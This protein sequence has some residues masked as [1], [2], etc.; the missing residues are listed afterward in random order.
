VYVQSDEALIK[1]QST[2]FVVRSFGNLPSEE[3]IQST[4]RVTLDVF[5]LQFKICVL[6]KCLE[7][8][9]KGNMTASI[10]AGGGGG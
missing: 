4:V 3:Q 2:Q 7:S 1:S 6:C 9:A 5:T 10:R 8:G